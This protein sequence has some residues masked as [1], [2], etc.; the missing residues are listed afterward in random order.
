M[1]PVILTAIVL[2]IILGGFAYVVLGELETHKKQMD[3]LDRTS[4]QLYSTFQEDFN[5]PKEK[6][7]LPKKT[8]LPNK[9]ITGPFV[10]TGV[11][12][13]G[14]YYMIHE[15]DTPTNQVGH[16]MTF[17]AAASSDI[18][19]G[20]F[21]HWNKD[22][23]TISPVSDNNNVP[24]GIATQTFTSPTN[25]FPTNSPLSMDDLVKIKDDL[26]VENP[27]PPSNLLGQQFFPFMPQSTP[28]AHPNKVIEDLLQPKP[29]PEPKDL[30]RWDIL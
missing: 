15:Y 2:A 24:I 25:Y 28:N 21:V 10:K 20:Q 17:N 14:D 19:A 26:K 6:V 30:D 22:D 5:E 18:T 3:V 4:E 23:G 16:T 11:N 29:K 27:P 12:A 1:L 13:N 8:V 9:H 7:G